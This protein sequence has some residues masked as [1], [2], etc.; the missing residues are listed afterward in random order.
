MYG[1]NTAS[2]KSTFGVFKPD[3]E[4]P[5]HIPRRCE[6]TF[7]VYAAISVEDFA[8]RSVQEVKDAETQS[9]IRQ[10][11][12]SKDEKMS[13][14]HGSAQQETLRTLLEYLRSISSR[15]AC[16]RSLPK[17]RGTILMTSCVGVESVFGA[18]GIERGE[19]HFDLRDD[20]HRISFVNEARQSTAHNARLW[21]AQQ[22]KQSSEEGI[23]QE[24]CRSET[25]KVNAGNGKQPAAPRPNFSRSGESRF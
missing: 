1:R 3:D 22:D 24:I 23:C 5:V 13:T 18:G 6:F 25:C 20:E 15:I 10:D 2:V 16:D 19:A 14:R 9:D 11:L 8:F 4:P 17:S 12:R 21:A 7:V